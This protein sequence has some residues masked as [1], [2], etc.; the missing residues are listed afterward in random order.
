MKRVAD[1]TEN[2]GEKDKNIKNSDSFCFNESF[3]S[4]NRLVRIAMASLDD[5]NSSKQVEEDRTVAIEAA[6]VRIMKVTSLY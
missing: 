2:S 3:S 4:P 1:A 6:I 5:T